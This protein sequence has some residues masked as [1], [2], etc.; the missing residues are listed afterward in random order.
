MP[1]GFARGHNLINPK[2]L[3]PAKGKS[4]SIFIIFFYQ[5]FIYGWKEK[6]R[7]ALKKNLGKA[8]IKLYYI[9]HHWKCFIKKLRISGKFPWFHNE[10]FIW[11]SNQKPNKKFCFNIWS[12]L[13][14]PWTML[15][16]VI[17]ILIQ[18]AMGFLELPGKF[19]IMYGVVRISMST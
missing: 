7:K 11:I 2:L 5:K 18:K 1:F 10:N 12:H 19:L 14:T 9:F 16:M 17:S 3:E 8:F 13:W 6:Q 4:K 15:E